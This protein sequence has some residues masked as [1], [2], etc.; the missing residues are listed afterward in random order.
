MVRE[1]TLEQLLAEQRLGHHVCPKRF[2]P[3]KTALSCWYRRR[4]CCLD[5]F[6][7]WH[8]C[9]LLQGLGYPQSGPLQ[10]KQNVQRPRRRRCSLSTLPSGCMLRMFLDV[11]PTSWQAC[12]HAPSQQRS[13]IWYIPS[14]FS[15]GSL[16]HGYLCPW[17][18]NLL[19]QVCWVSIP[20]VRDVAAWSAPVTF[21]RFN[22]WSSPILKQNMDRQYCQLWVQHAPNLTT[23]AFG[24]DGTLLKDMKEGMV[25]TA[26]V[27]IATR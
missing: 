27:H 21:G 24:C 17:N 23:V 19:G 9:S 20:N 13:D 2:S 4:I 8:I 14:P 18:Y 25:L 1:A 10:F 7:Q 6:P 26:K 5:P 12:S 15:G 3:A 16:G 22:P 11:D